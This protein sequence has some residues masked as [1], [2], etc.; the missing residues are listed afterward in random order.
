MFDPGRLSLLQVQRFMV[1][2]DELHFTRAAEHLNVSQPLLSAQIRELEIALGVKLFERTSRRV[3]LSEAGAIFRRQAESLL[4]GIRD[5]VEATRE[6]AGGRSAPM[7]IG[8]TDEFSRHVLPE[9]VSRLKTHD[10]ST[11]IHLVL[12]AVPQ[13]VEAITDGSL[14]V[15]LLCPM[16]P[17]RPD[18]SLRV[19]LLPDAQVV[20]GIRKDHPLAQ[21]SSLTIEELS[22]EPFVASTIE[23]A[24]S[25]LLADRLFAEK[26]LTRKIAQRCSDPHLMN[27]LVAAGV[28]ILLAT[29]ADF[30]LFSAL[31]AIPLEPPVRI[32]RG[33]IFRRTDQSSLT[34]RAVELLTRDP[35]GPPAG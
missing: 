20:V 10:I 7:R 28:G 34:T 6:A 29:E 17:R 26:N 11:E 23:Q 12:G 5:M 4:V 24:G 21:K 16:P 3:E 8:Y 35:A 2:A 19:R 22:D 15:A 13:L 30:A 25:E 9:L 14:E 27:G 1:V 33:A 32:T 18:G 31:A